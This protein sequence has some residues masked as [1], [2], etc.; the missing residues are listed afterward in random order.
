MDEIIVQKQN[1]SWLICVLED[2]RIVEKTVFSDVI[3]PKV[4]MNYK[5]TIKR[6]NKASN[7]AFVDIGFEKLGYL[8]NKNIDK[9]KV[10]EQIFVKI[11][12]EE[13]GKKGP[14]LSISKVN[15][16]KL[17]DDN[18]L[19][20]FLFNNIIKNTTKCIYTN[21]SN[22]LQSMKNKAVEY[23]LNQMELICDEKADFIRDFGILGEFEKIEDRKIWLKSGGYIVI[24]KAEAL[25]AI[26]V[27]SGK[28]EGKKKENKSEYVLKINKEAAIEVIRQIRLKN[29]G[30]IIVVDFINME[31]SED[32][33]EIIHIMKEE[34]KKDRSQVKIYSFSKLGLLELT[35]MKL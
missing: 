2:N 24:D 16:E 12:K 32:K 27:N 6:I 29:M 15:D 34:A 13:I 26:D 28:Y 31:K 3:K 25:W 23:N 5:G 4:G 17:G 9:F 10:G 33:Q 14:K 19:E 20:S 30:G 11:K 8:E 22:I 7:T 18:S 35:R 21:D 1:N